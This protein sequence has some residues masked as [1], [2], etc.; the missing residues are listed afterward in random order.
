MHHRALHRRSYLLG[1]VAWGVAGTCAPR[2]A[3]AQDAALPPAAP[4]ELL[5]L[6]A[7]WPSATRLGTARLRYFGLSVYD[8]ALWAPPGLTAARYA[9]APFALE[10]RYLRSLSGDAIAQRSIK[11]MRRGGPLAPTIEEPWL[12][13]M[14]AAFPDVQSG[15]R[16]TGVNLPKVGVRVYVNGQV[17]TEISDATFGERFFGM[18]LAPWTSEPA[19]RLALLEG[20]AP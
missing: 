2:W 11:E 5:A 7:P 1:L 4:P 20:L 18:W 10:L 14:Q 8:A 9:N 16:I 3:R 13:H 6:P 15:D 17:R 19:M 12:R